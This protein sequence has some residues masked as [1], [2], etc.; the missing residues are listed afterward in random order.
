MLVAYAGKD[1][2]ASKDPRHE[3]AYTRFMNGA[4]TLQIAK[5]YHVRESTVLR[6]ITNWRC[7]LRG[8]PCPYGVRS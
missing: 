8:L 6:W 4:D 3:Y 7:Y 5:H 2:E 1:T